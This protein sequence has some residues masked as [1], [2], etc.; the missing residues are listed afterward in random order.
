MK[1]KWI[2]IASVVAVV[3]LIL[4]FVLS[5]EITGVP[6]KQ[7]MADLDE[8]VY[9]T[10]INVSLKHNVDLAL[11]TDTVTAKYDVQWPYATSHCV[12]T[13]QYFHNRSLDIW[14]LEGIDYVSY[15]YELSKA[16]EGRVFEDYKES[17]GVYYHIK[18]N[19]VDYN[20]NMVDITYTVQT[21]SE[22]Y[23]GNTQLELYDEHE[24]TWV[25]SIHFTPD[26]LWA[27]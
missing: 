11:H 12:Y 22:T 2:L 21:K 10:P 13:Y 1:K 26:G 7:V 8:E 20:R 9:G 15:E 27:L 24:L 25:L 17:V 6:K 23:Q 5:S 16:L 18:V 14:E 4:V 3:T 19:S